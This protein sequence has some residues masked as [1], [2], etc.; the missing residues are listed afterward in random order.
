MSVHLQSLT[1][2][3]S[4]KGLKSRLLETLPA[5]ELEAVLDLL[6]KRFPSNYYEGVFN[7]RFVLENCPRQKFLLVHDAA[8]CLVGFQSYLD[9]H[10]NYD[11][12][13]IPL[14]G[15][16]ILAAAND[17]QAFSVTDLIKLEMFSYL[18][19]NSEMGVGIARKVMDGYWH[20]YG[21]LGITNFAELTVD[22]AGIL[23]NRSHAEF[24]DLTESDLDN[25]A[26]LFDST[27]SKVLGPL[28]RDNAT[29]KYYLKK[30]KHQK[31]KLFRIDRDARQVGYVALRDNTVLELG[32]HQDF[33]ATVPQ[34][35]RE[36]F[37][38]RNP[39]AKNIVLQIGLENPLMS[40]IRRY[41]HSIS[42]RFVWNGGHIVRI[43]SV[44]RFLEKITPA[45]NS[46][47]KLSLTAN[48]S[49][50]IGNFSFLYFDQ[51]LRVLPLQEP[52]KTP[53]LSHH[54]WQML[55]FGVVRPREIRALSTSEK[56]EIIE[57]MFPLRFPQIPYL[58][59]G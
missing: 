16:S 49:L 24:R 7:F 17:R 26:E 11:G 43:N 41:P 18:A 28:K 50:E 10:F 53:D 15:L 1:D 39:C 12:I 14:T 6:A 44:A 56:L 2:Q 30:A 31:I 40:E 27:Y 54:D 33:A 55:I 58:D 8:N 59:E 57:I 36:F 25:T 51:R 32:A 9:R 21:F 47:L 52:R 35:L 13:S 48:F 5:S 23:K 3:S 37:T 22:V 34:C 20:P 38:Q 45:L 46:R 42:Q 29:W 4:T 19:A